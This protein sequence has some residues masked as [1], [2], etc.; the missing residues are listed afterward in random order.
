M[1]DYFN[2]TYLT[3]EQKMTLFQMRSQ[4]YPVYANTKFLNPDPTCPCC[5]LSEDTMGH[6]IECLVLNNGDLLI[7]HTLSISDIYHKD[8]IRQAQI[9]QIFEQAIKRRKIYLKHIKI[10]R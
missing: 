1:Q 10:L 8:V 5:G 9:T 7:D 2:S 4:C 6:Q 3:T